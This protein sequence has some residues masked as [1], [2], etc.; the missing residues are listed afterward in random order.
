MTIK[1]KLSK[2]ELERQINSSYFER[3]M[4]ANG[5]LVPLVRELLE[6]ITSSF[7]G[8]YV[9]RLLHL[10]EP[11]LEKDLRRSIS[12]NITKFLLEFGRD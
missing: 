5:K 2:R 12:Q 3:V 1:E 9:L 10:P 4:L 11:H 7:K 8:T 6:G